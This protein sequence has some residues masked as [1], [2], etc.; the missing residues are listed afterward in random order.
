MYNEPIFTPEKVSN[1]LSTELFP[2]SCVW[3]IIKVKHH[4]SLSNDNW[5]YCYI[6]IDIIGIR[7]DVI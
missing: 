1:T 2:T 7:D 3:N 5:F 4:L 6:S